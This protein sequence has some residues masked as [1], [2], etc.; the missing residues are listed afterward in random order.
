M[1]QAA[2]VLILTPSS[3]GLA[4]LCERAA[5]RCP[6]AIRALPPEQL[7]QI[8]RTIR[9]QVLAQRVP[10]P[11]EPPSPDDVHALLLT[12]DG[13]TQRGSASAHALQA[14]DIAEDGRREL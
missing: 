14:L 2:T 6:Q 4:P 3:C 13:D 12:C 1:M 10:A 7:L 5:G 11:D 8:Y 9:S